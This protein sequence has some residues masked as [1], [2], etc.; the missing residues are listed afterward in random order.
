MQR[1]GRRRWNK[2]MMTSSKNTNYIIGMVVAVG[3]IGL[4]LASSSFVTNAFAHASLTLTADTENVNPISVVIGH[5]NEPTF[6]VEPGIHDGRHNVEVFLEDAETALPLT[7]A[8]L[9]IDK[10]YFRDIESFN[11]ATSINDADAIE[12]NVTL[13]SVFGDPGHYMASQIMQPGIYGYNINGTIN[14]FDIAEV[15]INATVFCT[16]DSEGGGGTTEN[17][18]KFNSEGWD[19]EYGCTSDIN[20]LY[21]PAREMT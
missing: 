5:S 20:D 13:G 9:V 2:N 15:P 3:T 18:S 8:H 7:G 11:N 1:S 10:Y 12:R 14:Y 19:G 21:F 16:I 4:L 6:G 17:T